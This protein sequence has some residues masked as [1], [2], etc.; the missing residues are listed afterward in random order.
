MANTTEMVGNTNCNPL[1]K[2][3]GRDLRIPFRSA[4]IEDGMNLRRAS[5]DRLPEEIILGCR[6]AMEEM[7]SLFLLVENRHFR[8]KEKRRP[9]RNKNV[10][11]PAYLS[12]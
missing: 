1:L 2:T 6:M 9:L 11:I 8:T 5:K 10:I 3:R 7:R 4:G 12:D